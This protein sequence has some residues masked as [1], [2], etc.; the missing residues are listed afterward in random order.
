MP[1]V[2]KPDMAY[3][4]F[5]DRVSVIAAELGIAICLVPSW[6]R[7]LNGGL[8][9]PP[10]IFDVDSAYSYAKF[11]G[12]RYPFHP[13]ILGGDSNRYW[14]IDANKIIATADDL[15]GVKVVDFGAVTESMARGLIEGEAE[16]IRALEG[17]V[18]ELA[19]GYK[20]FITYHSTQG[21]G[22]YC[23]SRDSWG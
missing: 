7:W 23:R 2:Y 4:D 17:E 22:V 19:R 8:H 16:A 5:V 9:G 10:V 3:F 21:K 15:S 6:G 18:R 20:T 14:N 13:F 11:L 1:N 12:K